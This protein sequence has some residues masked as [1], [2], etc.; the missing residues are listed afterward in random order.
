MRPHWI[1]PSLT[2]PEPNV[3]HASKGARISLA[4]LAAA[5]LFSAAPAAGAQ[6]ALRCEGRQWVSA[7]GTCMDINHWKAAPLFDAAIP[8]TLPPYCVYTWSSSA[9][10]SSSDIAQLDGLGATD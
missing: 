4:A 6:P 9:A 2:P 8:G 10:P 1:S 3:R 5:A 7:V